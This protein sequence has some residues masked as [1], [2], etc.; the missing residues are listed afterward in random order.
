MT[1]RRSRRRCSA[2]PWR[3]GTTSRTARRSPKSSTTYELDWMGAIPGKRESRRFEGDHILTMNEIDGQAVFEDA[4]AYGG[5]GFDHHPP[6]GFHDKVNPSTHQYLRGPHNVPLRSLYSRNIANLFFAGRNI[7]ATHYALSSTRVMLTCAQLGEAVGMAASHA[8]RSAAR[9]AVARHRRRHPRHPARPAARRPP[10]PRARPGGRRRHRTRS[11]RH[12]LERLL[13][14]GPGR[15]L[16]RRSL[17]RRAHAAT[18][19][20]QRASLNPS[21]LLIDADRDTAT[22]LPLP[23][24]SGEQIHLPRG[25]RL[26]EGIIEIPAGKSQWIELPI[27][28]AIPRPGWHF[29]ILGKNP[30]LAVHMTE[31]P[32]G[33]RWYYPRP[34]DPIRPNPFHHVDLALADD[35]HDARRGRRRRRR[36]VAGLERTCP[37]F[38][39]RRACSSISPI[40]AAPSPEQALYG[41]HMVV[42]GHSR[43]TRTPNLWVSAA[44]SFEE[45]EWI[46][47]ELGKPADDQRGPAA[48]RLVAALP[49]LAELAGLSAPQHAL[50]H[51]RLPADRP[52]TR[53]APRPTIAEVTGNF[54]RNRRHR[55]ALEG[56]TRLRLEILATNGLARAQVYE[57]RVLGASCGAP[58]VP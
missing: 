14:A 37:E 32:P 42:N 9:S 48:L 58:Q 16:G 6:G 8:V 40:A 49:L 24:G 4:V 56:I 12:R 38:H 33:K 41:P 35:R 31:T 28:C 3:S 46:E 27:A 29:L 43:P 7:S 2:S 1:R 36:R 5:W 26:T 47:L 18:A 51:P 44:S 10:H 54:Q 34:E 57:I 45:P 11:H 20:D 53:T 15:K 21:R 19:G 23:P 13:G 39:R 50:D 30:D 25:A 55:V 52:T 22:P 17:A